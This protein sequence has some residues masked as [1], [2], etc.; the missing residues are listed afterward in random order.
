M[1]N[2]TL[3]MIAIVCLSFISG[4]SVAESFS[5][6][7]RNDNTFLNKNTPQPNQINFPQDKIT[8]PTNLNLV[9]QQKIHE[10]KE[11]DREV[12]NDSQQRTNNFNEDRNNRATRR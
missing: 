8:K 6:R 11:G 12:K 3:T 4:I 1:K 5:G 2:T 9:S 10:R 7:H